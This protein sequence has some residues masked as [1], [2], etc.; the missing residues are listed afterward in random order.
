MGNYKSM[1]KTSVSK[2]RSP[3]ATVTQG[4]RL[5][6]GRFQNEAFWKSHRKKYSYKQDEMK[7]SI[8]DRKYGLREASYPA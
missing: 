2:T 7:I 5:K 4:F 1:S 3:E 8:Q 6:T